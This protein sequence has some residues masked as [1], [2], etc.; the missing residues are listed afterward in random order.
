[1]DTVEMRKW[2]AAR[3]D[4]FDVELPE[5][6]ERAIEK[7]VAHLDYERAM[8]ALETYRAERPYRGFYIARFNYHYNRLP[9]RSAASG[10]DPAAARRAAPPENTYNLDDERTERVRYRDLPDEFV[11]NCR[12]WFEGWGWPEN[13]RGWRL[14]CLDA[15]AGKPVDQYRCHPRIGSAGWERERRIQEYAAQLN[16]QRML[17]DLTRL[18]EACT[19]AGIDV[20]TILGRRFEGVGQTPS[21]NRP[22]DAARKKYLQSLYWGCKAYEAITRGRVNAK[23]DATA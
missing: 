2:N 21:G 19:N 10:T 20:E 9:E 22:G 6:V 18:Q 11:A 4:L 23:I 7:Q 12:T 17:A 15:Y 13:S 14:L 8:E 16:H 3:R 5:N 1:M